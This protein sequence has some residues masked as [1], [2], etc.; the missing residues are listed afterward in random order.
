MSDLQLG[1]ALTVSNFGFQIDGIQIEAVHEISGFKQDQE[2][3]T[4]MQNTA[5]GITLV[6]NMPGPQPG[7]SI[8]VVFGITEQTVFQD[9]IKESQQ[10]AMGSARKN[11]SIILQDWQGNEVMRYNLISAWCNVATPTALKSGG[12]EA[13]T[14]TATVNYERLELA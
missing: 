4:Y 11:A 2:V 8:E 3:I 5:D 13:M 6:K 1:D 9:W 7:G 10:G 12:S 14:L